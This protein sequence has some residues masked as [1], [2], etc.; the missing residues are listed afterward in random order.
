MEQNRLDNKEAGGKKKKKK[1]KT[2][3]NV[4]Q[5]LKGIQRLLVCKKNERNSREPPAC[6]LR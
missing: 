4:S 5:A 3:A 6:S 2:C 1:S